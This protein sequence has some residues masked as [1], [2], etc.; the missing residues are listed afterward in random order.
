MKCPRGTIWSLE[1]D[2]G[3]SQPLCCP[4]GH[5][6]KIPGGACVLWPPAPRGCFLPSCS[7]PHIASLP[8]RVLSVPRVRHVPACWV[9]FYVLFPLPVMSALPGEFPGTLQI[10]SLKLISSGRPSLTVW[11]RLAT[12]L[13][14]T[15]SGLRYLHSNVRVCS[16]CVC[17]NVYTS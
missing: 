12:F 7:Q 8:A 6:C 5:L 17:V 15:F 2:P 3:A 1:A 16:Y 11:F 4:G 10:S 13:L 9:A 14:F